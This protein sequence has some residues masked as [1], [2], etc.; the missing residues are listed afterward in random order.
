MNLIQWKKSGFD[1]PFTELDLLQNEINRLFDNDLFDSRRPGVGAAPLVDFAEDQDT[2]YL[3][4]DL[5]GVDRKDI[6]ITVSRNV[7]IIKG[8][9]KAL[10][11]VDQEKVYHNELWYG[12]FERSI[13]LPE[14]A[15]DGK[16]SAELKNG[17]LSV[18]IAKKDSVKPRQI[19][20]NS[21]K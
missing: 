10:K 21:R 6:D 12:T 3:Y 19:T 11:D 17:V 1:S 16:I 13:S 8:E 2:Y 20:I 18:V 15:D 7:L 14:T 5:P 4:M 9:K